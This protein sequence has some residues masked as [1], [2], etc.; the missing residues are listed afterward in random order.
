MDI[1]DI[2]RGK[3]FAKV[4]DLREPKTT[5]LRWSSPSPISRMCFIGSD[6]IHFLL[7]SNKI[8]HT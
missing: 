2:S 4:R 5:L 6:C 1:V 7:L 3:N 8:A